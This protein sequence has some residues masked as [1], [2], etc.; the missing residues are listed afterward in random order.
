[1]KN[2]LYVLVDVTDDDL[3]N[4]S[5]EFWF[6]DGVEIF[7]DAD[8]SRSGDYDDNDY[9][10]FFVWDATS[11]TMGKGGQEQTDE[12]QYKFARTDNGYRLEVSFPWSMLQAKPSPGRSIGFDVQVNDD[13]GGGERDSKLAWNAMEDDAY[14]NPRSFGVA[15]P[16]GLV[17]WYKLDESGGRTA[18]DSSGNGHDATVQGDPTWKP[19]GGKIGGAIALDGDGDFIDIRG[20]SDFDFMG[21][22]TVAAWINANQ[23]DRPWQAIVTKGD[24]TWRI[25]RNNE[26]STLEFAC[27]GLD[28]PGGNDYG[29][30]YGNKA[31]S[32]GEW[33]HIAGVYDGKR[34]AVYVDGAL[35]ASQEASGTINT[36]D[37]PVQI[38]ANTDMQDRFWNGLI[39]DVHLYNYGVSA[40]EIATLAGR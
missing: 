9:Q 15:Q 3:R 34:M 17:A 40:A 22:V 35:D 20:E 16:L 13:D 39:D 23:L 11:P 38:G 36:N 32:L 28:I 21:G 19:A 1:D 7:I 2:N 37:T 24:N 33:H 31:I 14:L 26:E 30:L 6:D 10:Y 8:H 18:A 27:T 4:D 5:D 12:T 25:Q 29:S